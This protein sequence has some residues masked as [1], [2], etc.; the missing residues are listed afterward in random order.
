MLVLKF[1]FGT[2]YQKKSNMTHKQEQICF[3]TDFHYNSIGV[4]VIF[5]VLITNDSEN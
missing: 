1:Y 5:R 3:F 4:L 2:Y